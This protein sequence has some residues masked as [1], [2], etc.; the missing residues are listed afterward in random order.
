MINTFSG[1]KSSDQNALSWESIVDTFEMKINDMFLYSIN[2]LLYC[3][4]PE[5]FSGIRFLLFHRNLLYRVRHL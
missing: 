3:G 1:F 2:Q 5:L 4:E